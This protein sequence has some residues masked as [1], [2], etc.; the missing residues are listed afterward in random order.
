[1]AVAERQIQEKTV[2]DAGAVQT[3][4]QVASPAAEAD[5]SKDVAARVVWFIAGVLLTLLG[6]R[7]L[8]ALLGANATNGFASFIYSVTHP[9]VAPFFGVFGYNFTAGQARFETYT[10]LAMLIY[11]L[12]AY[13][14]ARLVTIT[15][16]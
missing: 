2:Q 12:I 9:F 10:L 14:I 4:R 16:R 7:F 8:F 6:L 11:A 13:A 5:H 1:M 15:R 3:T